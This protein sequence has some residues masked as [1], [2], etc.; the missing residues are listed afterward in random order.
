[1]KKI[2]KALTVATLGLMTQA[3]LAATQTRTSAFEYDAATGLLTKE[4]IEPDNSTPCLVTTYVYDAYGNKTS[5]TTRNCNGSSSEAAAPTGDAVFQARTSTSSFAA[6]SVVIGGVTYNWSAGQFPTTSTN[7]LNQSETKEY[8][9]R[10]GAVTKLTGPNALVTQWTYDGFGRKSSETRA[11]GTTTTWAYTRCVDN[12]AGC[13]TYGV[14]L[15]TETS[16]GAPTKTVYFDSLN[17]EIRS[18]VQGFDGT[19]VRKDTQYD[20]LGRVAQVSKPY[21]AAQTIYWTAFSYD[22]LGRITDAVEP[23]TTAGTPKTH[24]DYN[25]LVVTVTASNN[26]AGT[27]M[28]GGAVQTK[29]TTKNSQGQVAQVADT[30]NNTIAYSYDPFGNLTQTN[31]GGVITTLGYDLRGRKTSMADPDMGS[32]TYAYNALGELIR[33]I[34]AKNQTVSMA[35]DLLGRMTTRTEPDLIS[36]WTF[37]TCTKGVGKLCSASADNGYARTH[38]YDSLGRPSN[39]SITIDTS[40]SVTTSYDSAGRVDTLTYPTGFAVKNIYNSYGYLSKVQRTNDLDTTIYWQAN[41]LNAAGQVTGELLGNGLTS[42][43]TYDTLFRETGT[44]ASNAG[45]AVHNL[46]FTFDAIGNVIQRQ[47]FVQAITE[48]FAYDT[49]N[50]LISAS[51]AG[52]TTRSFDYVNAGSDNNNALGNIHYK[53]DV[54]TYTYLSAS[55]TRPHAVS[56]VTNGSVSNSVTATYSYDANGNL[57]SASGTIYPASGSVTF[58][59]TLTYKSFNAPATLTHI[60]GGA[61]YSYTYTYSVEHERVKLVTTRPDDTITTIYVHPAGKGA[62]LYEKEMHQV[63]G[64]TQYKH[65]VNGGSGLVG[66]FVTKS[67]YATG[68]GPEMRYYHRDHLGSIVAITN[69]AAAVIERLAY[70]PFGERRYP[71]GSPE[72]R[73]S[74]LIGVTT[75]R[76]FTAHEHLDEMMLI[77]M[78]GRIYD[79]VVAR[80]ITADLIVQAPGN[81]Q[82]YNRYS[83]ALNNP[84]LYAD[85]TGYCS[86][87][88]F[89]SHNCYSQAVQ[90]ITKS[91]ETIVHNVL[92]DPVRTAAVVVAAYYT[93]QW[94]GDTFLTSA[95]NAAAAS[96]T[97]TAST[98]FATAGVTLEAGTLTWAGW[99]TVGAGAGFAGAFA[100]TGG[101]LNAA[102]RSALAGSVSGGIAGYFGDEYPIGRVG[103][104]ALGG[105]LSSVLRGGSFAAGFRNELF[106]SSL[107]YANI[108]MREFQKA[109]SRKD[110]I[111]DGTGLSQGLFRDWFKLAGGRSG[112]CTFLGCSQ[113]GP[114]MLFDVPYK[115]GSFTDMMLEAFAGPH[116]TANMPWFYD[117]ESGGLRPL[118]GFQNL[119]GEVLGDFTT[120]LLFAAPFAAGAI[121][122]QTYFPAYDRIRR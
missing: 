39:L 1:M 118:T 66:V 87:N 44:T 57:T 63:T 61:T 83:Y 7:Q 121:R 90:S 10:L 67:S 35:Y 104:N 119:T 38:A 94:I 105:G 25:G 60:Q 49:L 79:P 40:Y 36:T 106:W 31:A 76:G 51:G 81:L 62:L 14:Y 6:G 4:I 71:N 59:R 8:D 45:G 27:N 95:A 93:G 5:A 110:P 115:I 89:A 70:E 77:H 43:Y 73:A 32:W 75:D 46:S 88:P 41:S 112:V 54:G 103:A 97:L 98:A 12:P 114:G 92:Q 2:L 74:P 42:S 100:G 11:D 122:E 26:G 64:V 86:V 23:T 85:P 29:T 116:D 65:Y 24:T 37:D 84:L 48:N 33:Q 18:E 22:V 17:R 34:D 80:F 68:D 72:N 3:G 96:P 107:T 52:L 56:S 117:R 30:Q 113:S 82:S 101:D 102:F 19:L 20:A 47:D 109:L 9:P 78:N 69:P 108:Q 53:S 91:F 21:Y 55:N 16:T 111:N 28:P 120:S 15:V 50:R 99:A 58:S 13:P